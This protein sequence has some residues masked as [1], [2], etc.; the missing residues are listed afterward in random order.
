MPLNESHRQHR[1]YFLLLTSSSLWRFHATTDSSE[2]QS[3]IFET[4]LQWRSCSVRTRGVSDTRTP[5]STPTRGP[6]RDVGVVTAAVTVVVIPICAPHVAIGT[7]SQLIAI[8]KGSRVGME[9]PIVNPQSIVPQTQ[10]IPYENGLTRYHLAIDQSLSV[11]HDSV[12]VTVLLFTR[13]IRMQD[14]IPTPSPADIT[15]TAGAIG[16]FPIG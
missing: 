6:S 13:R 14:G 1:V 10:L 8:D 5:R 4:I 11:D 7:G 9:T 3:F 15:H 16:P 2:W 12:H